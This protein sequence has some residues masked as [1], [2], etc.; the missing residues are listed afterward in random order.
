MTPWLEPP[1]GSTMSWADP[2]GHGMKIM[3]MQEQ[4]MEAGREE[5]AG[6]ATAGF[7]SLAALDATGALGL[8]LR[9][10][11][12]A[13]A[14][15]READPTEVGLVFLWGTG[16]ISRL[17]TRVTG[18]GPS[19]VAIVFDGP[20]CAW[21]AYYEAL[22]GRGVEGPRPMK[23]MLDWAK[24]EPGR[25]METIWLRAEPGTVARARLIAET[26][27]GAVGYGG[28]QLLCML[29]MLRWGWRVPR[30]MGRVVCSELAARVLYP[31]VWRRVDFDRVTPL[32]LLV[33]ARGLEK[34]HEPA[35]GV[36]A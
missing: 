1:G 31:D 28:L 18:G 6:D 15:R 19:H 26:F 21:P 5:G 16:L 3:S 9:A 25:R 33:W 4:S 23:H 36:G 10:G 13:L 27:V 20:T 34:V 2:A 11:F 24:A 8:A 32:D 12:G 7:A 17:I 29:S 30:S 22:F 35:M 14:A